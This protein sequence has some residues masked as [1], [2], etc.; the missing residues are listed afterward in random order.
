MSTT[1][2]KF[3]L[4]DRLRKSRE[5]AGLTQADIAE[6]LSYARTSVAAWEAGRVEP[7]AVILESWAAL[8][9]VDLDWLDDT[10]PSEAG[11]RS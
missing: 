9:G 7:R 8:T 2:P 5:L 6:R 11:D 4:A 1:R 3:D 10:P